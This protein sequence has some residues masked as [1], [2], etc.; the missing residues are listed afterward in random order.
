MMKATKK[1]SGFTLCGIIIVIAIAAIFLSVAI[2][3][4]ANTVRSAQKSAALSEARSNWSVAMAEDRICASP[5]GLKCLCGKTYGWFYDPLSGLFKYHS[6][7]FTVTY[8]TESFTV[9]KY[10]GSVPCPG[11]TESESG[12]GNI[13]SWKDEK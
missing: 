1:K 11:I 10:D 5:D 8:D 12:F 3:V 6:G 2:P 13:I 7:K 9:K 4:F